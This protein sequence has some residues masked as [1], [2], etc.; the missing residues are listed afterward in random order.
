[1]R[2][3]EW[4]DVLRLSDDHL[5]V[6]IECDKTRSRA[7]IVPSTGGPVQAQFVPEAGV[8]GVKDYINAHSNSSAQIVPEAGVQGVLNYINAHSNPLITEPA[9]Q[10][11]M[12][13][14]KAH[15]VQP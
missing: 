3:D 15:G 12:D 9:V 8:Q 14:L 5:S 6:I 13:Y 1:M 2:S 10:S 11:V 7:A 4:V